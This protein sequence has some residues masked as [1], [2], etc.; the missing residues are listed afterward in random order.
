[1]SEIEYLYPFTSMT[2]IYDTGDP[3]S[4]R[5]NYYSKFKLY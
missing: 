5:N 1:M 3:N 2:F 4:P